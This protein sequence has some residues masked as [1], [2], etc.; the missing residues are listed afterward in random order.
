MPRKKKSVVEET[1]EQ[2]KLEETT[3][4]KTTV[5]PLKLKCSVCGN[6]IEVVNKNLPR[7]YC[8][9]CNTP[10]NSDQWHLYEVKE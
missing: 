8:K 9:K 10:I 6:I 3:V 4:E 1:E 5:A 7:V 2:T